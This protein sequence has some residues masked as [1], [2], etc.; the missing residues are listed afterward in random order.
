MVDNNNIYKRLSNVLQELKAIVNDSIKIRRGSKED[1][2]QNAKLWE[3]FLS[4]FFDFI[5][6]KEKETGENLMWGISI[7]K[8]MK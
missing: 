7:F 6:A 4:G 3:G 2:I 1:K 8:I 5:K